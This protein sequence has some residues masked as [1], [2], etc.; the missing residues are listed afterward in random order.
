MKY[1][2]TYACGHEGEISIFGP[3]K[4]HDWKREREFERLCPACRELH[5]Q[6]KREET[7]KKAMAASIEKGLPMLRGSE[8]Q[9]AWATTIRYDFVD[10]VDYTAESNQDREVDIPGCGSIT[11]EQWKEAFNALIAER[12][13]AAFWIENRDDYSMWECILEKCKNM[14]FGAEAST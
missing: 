10:M 14:Y 1:Y 5:K 13:K 3:T 7:N 6:K 2:G 8:K 12:T 9:I 11:A 4:D